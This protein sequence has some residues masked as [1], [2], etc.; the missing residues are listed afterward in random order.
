MSARISDDGLYRYWLRRDLPPTLANRTNEAGTCT[1]IMLNPSTADAEQD[2][3]TIRRCIG[4]AN[5]LKC[6]GLEV[7]NLYGYRTTDPSELHRVADAEG[8]ENTVHLRVA[9]NTPGPTIAA[10]GALAP[11]DRVANLLTMPGADNLYCLGTN[12]NGSPRHPLYLRADAAIRVWRP[13]LS[14]HG[15]RTRADR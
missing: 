7:V 1:F 8:P 9:L 6:T 2:D 10:W 14:S 11:P 12:Q 13:A 15:P 5:S 4:F 3:P